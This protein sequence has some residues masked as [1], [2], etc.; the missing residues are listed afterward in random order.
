[1]KYYG[2]IDLNQNRLLNPVVDQGDTFPAN[3]TTGQIFFLWPSNSYGID[4]GLYVYEG[5]AATEDQS[6]K[7]RDYSGTYDGE[8]YENGYMGWVKAGAMTED[9]INEIV[10]DLDFE[11]LLVEK[12]TDGDDANISYI[13]VKDRS[14][15]GS[16]TTGADTGDLRFEI[17]SKDGKLIWNGKA[18]ATNTDLFTATAGTNNNVKFILSGNGQFIINTDNAG[19]ASINSGSISFSANN[20]AGQ[21]TVTSAGT[22]AAAIDIDSAGGIDIDV[23]SPVTIDG[24]NLQ[25]GGT[26]IILHDDGG[27]HDGWV[28]AKAFLGTDPSATSNIAGHL[29]VQG[30]LTVQGNTTTLETQTVVV[31]DNILVLNNGE[32][33]NGVSAGQAGIEIDRGSGNSEYLIFLES[34][35]RWH[36]GF[37]TSSG[38]PQAPAVVSV[39]IQKEFLASDW[40]LDSGNIYYIDFVYEDEANAPGASGSTMLHTTDIEVKVYEKSAA[41]DYEEVGVEKIR[42]FFDTSN[43]NKA[44][45]RIYARQ[46]G[47]SMFDGKIVIVA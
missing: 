29:I 9:E 15:T 10:S 45:C 42:T 18:S 34:D 22:G 36:V 17:N 39:R 20:T 11:K 12:R 21:V 1:M 35:D 44:T 16:D 31:E 46:I 13:R 41:N 24:A 26:D 37:D 14:D 32:P 8:P 25:I 30:N 6:R 43:S 7:P 19:S 23:A 5:P 3:P 47:G 33:G 38:S 27:V 28:E 2:D 4:D 40:T